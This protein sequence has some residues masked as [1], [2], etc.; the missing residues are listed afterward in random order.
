[1]Q[2]IIGGRRSGKTTKAIQLLKDNPNLLLMVRDEGRKSRLQLYNPEVKDRIVCMSDI[3]IGK[4]EQGVILDDADLISSF[5]F[6]KEKGRK[7]RAIV[8]DKEDNDV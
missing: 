4:K 5:L 2:Y 8:L 6:H 3:L 7:L 1:M